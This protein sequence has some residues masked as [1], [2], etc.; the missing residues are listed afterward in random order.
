MTLLLGKYE[1]HPAADLFPM[2][3]TEAIKRLAADIKEHG[4]RDPVVMHEDKVLDGRN[5][6]K[7]C[8]VAKVKPR[9][10]EWF[11][12]LDEAG[13]QNE[14]PSPVEWVLSRNLH[15][16][17]LTES[18]RAMVAA[19]SLP[20]L[21]EE[22]K[23]RSGTRTDL[24][25]NLPTGEAGRAR[26][27]AAELAS[28]SPRS[29]AH[30]AKVVE[31]AIPELADAVR[32]GEVAVSTA[33]AIA[34]EPEEVQRE[35]VAEGPKAIREVASAK[36]KEKLTPVERFVLRVRCIADDSAKTAEQM[37]ADLRS[38]LEALDSAQ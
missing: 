22:A 38:A 32:S 27:K 20:M 26:D 17:H 10:V 11:N 35:L 12:L 14:N 18:Q 13:D 21:K 29:V 31:K 19:A 6:L 9:F 15:R 37:R 23:E 24:R 30:A 34:D 2:M 16:R 8:D 36:R 7:A 4:L 33:A 5:R 3:E 28:V 25:A 1:T